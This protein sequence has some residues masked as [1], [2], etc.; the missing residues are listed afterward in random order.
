MKNNHWLITGGTG[1]F[2][3][4]FTKYLLTYF[5]P[6]LI[7]IYSRDEHKQIQM[8]R[9][10]RSEHV[11]FVIGDVRDEEKL[12]R[13]CEGID[14]VV[15]AAALKH[16]R[17]GQRHPW[18]TI[19]TNVIG[20]HNVVEAAYYTKAKLVFLGTDKGVYPVNTYGKTKGLA[21]DIVL[22]RGFTVVRYGNVWGSRGSV[23]HRFKEQE[24]GGVVRITDVRMTRFVVTLPYAAKLVIEGFNHPGN[25]LVSAC[26]SMRIMDLAR[27]ACPDAKIEFIGIEA[28]EKLGEDLMSEYEFYRSK[29]CGWYFLLPP[30]YDGKKM[31]KVI[32]YNSSGNTMLTDDEIR[33]VMNGSV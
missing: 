11:Q 26:K 28:G 5:E 3:T 25:I 6:E 19:Q 33:E 24:Q 10:I 21:E 27:L 7:K 13:E 2:G 18:E 15:H 22:S 16:V 20:T 31:E 32:R 23:I 29:F 14:Y 12:F 1:T 30:D 9:E 8:E 17:T 4:Y